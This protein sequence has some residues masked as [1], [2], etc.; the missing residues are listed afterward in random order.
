MPHCS[1]NKIVNVTT[2]HCGFDQKI[3]S[4]TTPLFGAEKNHATDTTDGLLS[5]LQHTDFISQNKN[6]FWGAIPFFQERTFLMLI[7]SVQAESNFFSVKI[8]E[9]K[10]AQKM[11]KGSFFFLRC[12]FDSNPIVGGETST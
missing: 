6:I 1:L 5:A 7:S 3:V 9:E 11:W 10:F 8:G 12:G 4:V 2:P